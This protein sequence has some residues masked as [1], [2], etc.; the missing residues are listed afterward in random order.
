MAQGPRQAELLGLRWRDLDLDLATLSVSQVLYKRRGICQF[1]EPKSEHSWRRLGLTPS[2]TLFLRQYK[3]KKEKESL[4]LGKVPN[5]DDLVFSNADGRA[6]DPGTLTHNFAK[7]ARRAGLAG[8]RFHDLRHTFASLMLLAGIHPKVVSEALGDSSV[9]FTLDTYSHA[10]PSLQEAA[11]KR[12]D[13]MLEP[14]LTQTRDVSKMLA[15]APDLETAS[16]QIRTDDRRF[17]NSERDVP[18]CTTA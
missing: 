16:G 6:I 17:T 12:L 14:N 9:A 1:K 7:I 2:L 5:E 18:P 15:N 8:T 4:V 13:E 3:A 11:A 10:V